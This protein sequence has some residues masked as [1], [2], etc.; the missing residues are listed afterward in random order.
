MGNQNNELTTGTVRMFTPAIFSGETSLV[1]L[2][3]GRKNLGILEGD[4]VPQRFIPRMIRLYLAGQFPF[5]H[6][7]K[8]YDFREINRAMADVKRGD[9]IKPVLRINE[10]LSV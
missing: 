7:L 9:I 8:F 10:T 6:L 3:E 2:S 4:A 5:D 1:S